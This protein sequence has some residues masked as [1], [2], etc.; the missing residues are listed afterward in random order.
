MNEPLQ[1]FELGDVTLQSGAL[2][3]QAH[4]TFKTYGTLNAAG[5][6]AV[7]VPTFYTGTS[8]RNEGYFGPGR[9][10]DPARHFIISI[11]MFG[12]GLSTSPSNQAAPQDGPRCPST[13]LRDNVACQHRLVTQHL[14]VKHLALVTGWSMGACQ[15]YEWATQFPDMMDAILPFCGSA[16]KRRRQNPSVKRPESLVAPEQKCIGR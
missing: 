11:D 9:A 7:V 4:L 13:T 6:N 1:R 12:D 5:D 2:L 3:R 14:G 16:C 8:T 15:T 10:I